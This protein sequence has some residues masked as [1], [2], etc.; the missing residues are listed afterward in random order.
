MSDTLGSL[1]D[2]LSIAVLKIK[3]CDSDVKMQSLLEQ[4]KRYCAEIDQFLGMAMLDPEGM[5]LTNPSN[6]IYSCAEYARE[7]A[8]TLGGLVSELVQANIEMWHCQEVTYDQ[9]TLGRFTKQ[10]M[11]DY[12]NR[13]ARLNIERN[14]AIDRL[15]TFFAGLVR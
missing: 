2:K 3:H 5:V 8:S 4:R 14:Q 6:K 15:D 11:L 9:E 13:A 10:E 12:L 7:H 1:V